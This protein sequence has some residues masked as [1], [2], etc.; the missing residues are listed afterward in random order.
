LEVLQRTAAHL[1]GRGVP[2]ARLQA[3][4]LLAHALGLRRMQL[5]LQ[6]ERPLLEPELER[7]LDQLAHQLGKSRSSC[8]RE[9]ISQYLLRHGDDE[10]A[11]RQSQRLAELEA[12]NWSEQVPDWSDWTA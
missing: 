12:P 11:R 4:W 1:A 7:R 10:E 8:I 9:A 3:E 5:Y 2:R 6:F